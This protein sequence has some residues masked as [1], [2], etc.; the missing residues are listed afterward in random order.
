[1]KWF[2][3]SIGEF[4]TAAA[5]ATPTPGGGSVSALVAALGAAMGA[6]VANLSTGSKFE[7]I[8]SDV[9]YVIDAMTSCLVTFEHS[10][11]QDIDCFS[12]YMRALRL[13]KVTEVEKV[14]RRHALTLATK[15]ATEVPMR[16]AEECV[17]ALATLTRISTTANRQVLSDLGIAAI[18]L[19]SAVSSAVLTADINLVTMKDDSVRNLFADRRNLV[20]TSATNY[21]QSLLQTVHMRLNE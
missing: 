8:Q 1:V 10:L 5:S 14:A 2:D 6:M 18:L 21:R 4:L 20:V 9:Q 15:Q 7:S 19:E 16:L 13:P 11:E 12:S 3:K 17:V